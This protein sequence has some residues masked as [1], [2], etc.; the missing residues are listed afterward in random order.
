[1]ISSSLITA[2]WLFFA[3]WSAVLATLT[4]IAFGRDLRRPKVHTDP[5]PK[6]PS[7]DPSPRSTTL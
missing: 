2:R 5:Q 6:N 1:M 7:S 3:G 4:A